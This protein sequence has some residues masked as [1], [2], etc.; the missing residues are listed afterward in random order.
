MVLCG[1]LTHMMYVLSLSSQG[2]RRDSVPLS[3]LPS[4]YEGPG[5]R[6]DYLYLEGRLVKRAIH[7]ASLCKW[8]VEKKSGMEVEI[9]EM[10]FLA[11]RL[12]YFTEL[13]D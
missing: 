5:L 3:A 8:N 4:V 10:L 9:M 6:Q 13:F 1:L 2:G 12:K 11:Q 7:L